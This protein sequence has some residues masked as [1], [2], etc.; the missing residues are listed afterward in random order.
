MTSRSY[1]IILL[2]VIKKCF[3]AELPELHQQMSSTTVA[4]Q[5][6]SNYEKLQIVT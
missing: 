2:D 4:Q 6:L 1:E 3:L 5:T